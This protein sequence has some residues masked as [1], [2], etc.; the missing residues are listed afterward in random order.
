MEN[1]QILLKEYDTLRA[2]L[3]TRGTQVFQWFALVG[4]SAAALLAWVG[5][6]GWSPLFWAALA[7]FGAGL[8]YIRLRIHWDVWHA[9]AQVRELEKQIN[10]LAGTKLLTWE[11]H[12]GRAKL[13]SLRPRIRS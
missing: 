11:T 9:A 10:D 3:I 5:T 1:I 6:H 4:V 7:A 12:H 8:A 2:E 13:T